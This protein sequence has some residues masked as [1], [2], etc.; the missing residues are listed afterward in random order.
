M[1]R[2]TVLFISLCDRNPPNFQKN[3]FDMC[4]ISL[5]IEPLLNGAYFTESQS[6]L[7]TLYSRARLFL[8]LLLWY[9]EHHWENGPISEFIYIVSVLLCFRASHYVDWWDICCA[10]WLGSL[11][12]LPACIMKRKTRIL[13]NRQ[14]NN[15]T[16]SNFMVSILLDISYR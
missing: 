8:I 1:L 3:E 11:T 14:I 15:T 5:I 2:V 6:N 12:V 4:D 16:F 10:I 9:V 13:L 7:F